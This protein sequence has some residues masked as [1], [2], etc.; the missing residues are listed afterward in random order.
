MRMSAD[1]RGDACVAL[2]FALEEGD[3]RRPYAPEGQDEPLSPTIVAH[4]S[5]TID[6]PAEPAGPEVLEF[7]PV[8][9]PQRSLLRELLRLALPVLGEHVLHILVWLNDTYLANHL[10]AHR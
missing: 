9:P 7:Q 5:R 1:C 3:K 8:A 10:P 4:M 6:N 2:F